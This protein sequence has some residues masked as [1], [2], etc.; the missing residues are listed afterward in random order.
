[1]RIRVPLKERFWSKVEK[2]SRCWMWRGAR[3]AHGYGAISVVV[4]GQ[5]KAIKAHRLSWEFEHGP[6]APNEIV[7]H[8][9]DVPACVNPA[10]MFIGTIADNNKDRDQKGRNK[11]ARGE[12]SGMAILTEHQ[13][14]ALRRL[15]ATGLSFAKVAARFGVH[16]VTAF[17]ICSPH[18][19]GGWKHVA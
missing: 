7:C 11:Q 15:R 18:R 6:I 16:P 1:M 19:R 5:K 9:C 8:Q 13:V 4:D 2:T 10:H 12:K 14:R 3:D 17:D